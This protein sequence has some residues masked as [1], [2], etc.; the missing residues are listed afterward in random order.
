[1]Q[2]FDGFRLSLLLTRL[3]NWALGVMVG[4]ALGK[5]GTAQVHR[6]QLP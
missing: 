5:V 3:A 2:Q 6:Q 1:M 4:A